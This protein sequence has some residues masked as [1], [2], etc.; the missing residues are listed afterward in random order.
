MR[1][2]GMSVSENVHIKISLPVRE[3]L[4]ELDLAK[5]R[6][7]VDSLYSSLAAKG[8]RIRLPNSNT[9]MYAYM[10]EGYVFFYHE[11]SRKELADAGE[12][13]GY[14]VSDMRALLP[15]LM[16]QIAG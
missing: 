3:K 7:I 1:K 10:L 11:M 9:P 2:R 16:S 15:W 14:L 8:R 12:D 5:R 13:F 6:V 4:R